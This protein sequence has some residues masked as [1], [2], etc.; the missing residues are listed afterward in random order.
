[1]F[2]NYYFGIP[3]YTYFINIL[4]LMLSLDGFFFLF[5]PLELHFGKYYLLF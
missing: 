4:Q 2:F 1:M 5:F 3:Q